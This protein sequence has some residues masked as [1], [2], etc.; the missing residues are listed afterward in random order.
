MI[1]KFNVTVNGNSY[2]VEVEEIKDGAPAR[3]V[4]A[5]V[6]PASVSAPAQTQTV[7]AAAP[8]KP[9]AA[10]VGEGTPLLSPMPGTILSVAVKVGDTV[11]S[12]QVCVILEAM[13]MEN[14]LPSPI[15]GVVKS[16]SVTPG[17]SVNT[18]DVLVVI[19]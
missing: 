6:A 2:Q 19:G 14:E 18:S 8:A 3:P 1:K 13:K 9:T 4:L 15:D 16:I 7:Q 17:T 11:S 5:P 12:G 10:P